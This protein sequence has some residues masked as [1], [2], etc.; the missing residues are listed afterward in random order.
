MNRVEI[1]QQLRGSAPAVRALGVASLY[2]FGSVARNEAGP[3]SDVDL[4]VDI[5][6]GRTFSLIDLVGLKQL[7]EE[8][9]RTEVDVTT[10]S[11]LNPHLRADIE[12]AA[13]RAF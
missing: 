2:L 6:P 10:R 11:S 3:G 5:Q 8:R 9:L 13:V 12:M 7:L 4:F 1:L